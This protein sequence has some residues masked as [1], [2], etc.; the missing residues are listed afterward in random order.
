MNAIT[1]DERALI[2][3]GQSTRRIGIARRIWRSGRV[4]VMQR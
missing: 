1:S 2:T 4:L 3:R